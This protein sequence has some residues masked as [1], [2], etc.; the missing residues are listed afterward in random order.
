MTIQE[1]NS[2]I[3]LPAVC[4]SL[5]IK[6]Y[7]FVKMPK[8]GWFAYNKSLTEI[9]DIFE[10]FPEEERPLI[11]KRY[12]KDDRRYLDFAIT[13]SEYI[14]N[15][16]NSQYMHYLN[17]SVAWKHCI[18]EA[19]EGMVKTGKTTKVKATKFFENM[20]LT[21]LLDVGCGI[22]NER[23]IKDKYFSKLEWVPGHEGNRIIIPSYATP[24]HPCSF[25]LA[26]LTT[27]SNRKLVACYGEAGWYGK[28]DTTIV[29]NLEEL[30]KYIG[31]TWNHK[32][33]FWTRGVSDLSPTLTTKEQLDVW[34]EAKNTKIKY[35]IVDNLL[36]LNRGSELKN[37][38][39]SLSLAQVKHLETKL[40]LPLI[41][42]WK[43]QQ[44]EE[45]VVGQ[46]KFIKRDNKYYLERKNVTYEFT[47]FI[48]QI[49]G[50]V[51]KNDKFYRTGFIG[52]GESLYPFEFDN[53]VF[54]NP[55]GFYNHVTKF[56]FENGIGLPLILVSFQNLIT[57]VI[58]KFNEHNFSCF[59]TARVNEEGAKL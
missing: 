13:Y 18:Q 59:K 7:E 28:L 12:V 3:N 38:L 25:E 9:K 46:L 55:R 52:H 19:H 47:N 50:V 56:F 33:D 21:K 8:F 54:L 15:R 14:Q 41:E 5:G 30:T 23:I 39:K 1:F 58:N 2:K 4:Q 27:L 44:E 20:G 43:V 49:T 45:Q 16:L 51:K 26:A 31:Y 10:I 29:S 57:E 17:T 36:S 42:S 53:T 35:D 24:L 22:M 34:V 40:S 32:C 48:V 37:S 6:G 11:Y